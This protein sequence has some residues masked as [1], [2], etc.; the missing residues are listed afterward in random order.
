MLRGIL[1]V[2]EAPENSPVYVHCRQGHDRT[3]VVVA[4]YRISHDGWTNARAK[5]E[6]ELYGMAANQIAKKAFILGYH[7]D[8]AKSGAKPR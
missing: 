8:G 1:K 2:L 6:A 5:K 7:R 3:A 4:C